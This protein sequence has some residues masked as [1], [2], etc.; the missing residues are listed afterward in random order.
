MLIYTGHTLIVNTQSKS[1]NSELYRRF[2][3]HEHK[4]PLKLSDSIIES[5]NTLNDKY[6]IEVVEGETD[7]TDCFLSG[8]KKPQHM[9]ILEFFC[10]TKID[11]YPPAVVETCIN[12]LSSVARG[13]AN[14][15]KIPRSTAII[16]CGNSYPSGK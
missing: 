10:H 7:L 8:F 11:R 1:P 2:W 14:E 4:W 16:L 9:Y 12:Y 6:E 13:K 15:Y 3:L 5:L